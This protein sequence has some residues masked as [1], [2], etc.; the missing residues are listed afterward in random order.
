MSDPRKVY[1]VSVVNRYA[2]MLLEQDDTLRDIWISGEISNFKRH[3]SGHLY[4]TLK[5]FGGAINAV[6]FAS[7]ARGLR[8]YPENGTKVQARGSVTLY[9]KTGGYQLYVRRMEKEGVGDLYAAFDALKAKLEAE[10]LFDPS[11]KQKIP[12]FPRRIGIVTSPTGAAIK[13]IM[14]ISKRRNPGVDLVLY[15]ALVQGSDAAPTICKGIKVLDAMDEVDVII[16]GRGGGSMEDLWPFNEE[17]VARTIAACTTPVISAVG[18]ETDFT[19]A[20]FVSDMRAPTPSA[21]A[22]IAVADVNEILRRIADQHERRSQLLKREIRLS[23]AELDHQRTRLE[24]FSPN[25]KVRELRQSTDLFSERM[26]RSVHDRL[27]KLKTQ[28]QRLQAELKLASPLYPLSKG[29]AM[30]EAEDGSVL[31]S[32]SMVKPGDQM[33]VRLSDGVLTTEV[34]EIAVGSQ[35]G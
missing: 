23:R 6:M 32:V 35:N 2:K 13:D 14:Q 24:H 1:P 19:I 29:Y 15:P 30:V 3:S 11:H 7:D 17:S 34:K 28:L 8:F 20:D 31:T 9:E 4:F 25:G 16:V 21:A 12:M 5:D 22:E 10:G 18:H 33:T 26:E 27:E